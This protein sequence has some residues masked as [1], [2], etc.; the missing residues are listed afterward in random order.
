[1]AA[2]GLRGGRR[3][4]AVLVRRRA[5]PARPVPAH[6]DRRPP[7]GCDARRPLPRGAAARGCGA[8]PRPVRRD[9]L[10]CLRPAP[11]S[12]SRHPPRL[13]ASTHPVRTRLRAD[14][15]NQV[16]RSLRNAPHREGGQ[17]QYIERP[18]PQE[19]GD[20]TIPRAL[21]WASEHLQQSLTIER[22][23]A[24]AHMSERTFV[25]DFAAATG[26]TPAAWVRTRR[27]DEARRLL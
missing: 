3:R 6:A 20:G 23:A 13:D 8:A 25:R 7:A 24:V 16:A 15:A 9:A 10:A 17:A 27:L 19:P 12:A 11:A 21:E 2:G 18:V 14:R 1:R 4:R 22:L 26:T 5:P